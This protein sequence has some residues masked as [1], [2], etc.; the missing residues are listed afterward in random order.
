[1]YLFTFYKCWVMIRVDG[2]CEVGE[3][4]LI[5]RKPENPVNPSPELN[6]WSN[7][8]SNVS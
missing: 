8:V 4:I 5:G 3:V 6:P 7:E 1:M 2:V